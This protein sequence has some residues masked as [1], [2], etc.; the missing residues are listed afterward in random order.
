MEQKTCEQLT[1]QIKIKK[2]VHVDQGR[3]VIILLTILG[4]LIARN[5]Q[6]PHQFSSFKNVKPY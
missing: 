1:K 6:Q 2:V 5:W 4:K 3:L